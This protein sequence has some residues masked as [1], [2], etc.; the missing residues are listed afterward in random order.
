MLLF[1]DVFNELFFKFFL[2][3]AGVASYQAPNYVGDART[4]C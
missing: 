3:I 4:G 1:I 2:I